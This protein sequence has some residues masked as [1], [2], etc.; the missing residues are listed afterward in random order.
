MT[1]QPTS[2]EPSR[3]EDT[4][5]PDE[6]QTRQGNHA[7][8]NTPMPHQ[9]GHPPNRPESYPSGDPASSY[10]PPP[11][12]PPPQDGYLQPSD[13]NAVPG[14]GRASPAMPPEDAS[15]AEYDYAP[16]TRRRVGIQAFWRDLTLLGQVAGVAGLLIL[17]FFFV[18]WSFTPDV[19]AASIQITNRIPTTWHSGW[20]TAAGV[21]LFGGTTSFNIFPH[22]WL[23]PICALGMLFFAWRLGR[24]RISQ[25]LA[26]LVITFI[27]LFAVLLEMLF[28][29]Q[30]T[31]FQAAIDDLAGGR[32][33]QT[34]YGVSWGFWLALVATVIALGV[35]V[36]LLYYGYAP[37]TATRPQAPRLPR[38]QQPFPTT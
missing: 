36:Y 28:L 21:P 37:R 12:P 4:Y 16:Q 26:A 2:N 32:V 3:P 11:Y 5:L 10:Y 29:V 9:A 35:G 8:G 34:L 20:S 31:S 15:D 38:D 14:I 30:I 24:Q 7:P 25:R 23:V 22:L 19:S 1:P 13:G 27:A 17:I 6:H 33:N 18:P